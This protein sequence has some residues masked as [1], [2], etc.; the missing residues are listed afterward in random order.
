MDFGL[1]F[2]YVF[3]DKDWFR[4][5][6]ILSLVALIPIVGQFVLYGWMMKIARK[7]M[8]HNLESLPE[9]EF[10]EDLSR[11]FMGWVISLVYLLPIWIIYGLFFI[12]SMAG[13]Y[14]GFD[15]TTNSVSPIVS[16]CGSLFVIAYGLLIG[17]VLPAAFTRY[18]ERNS[19]GDAFNF[20][21]VFKMVTKNPGTYLIVLL[22]TLVVGLIV[23]FGL[24]AC[25]IG[26][27]WTATYAMA[28]QGHLYGQ[29]YNE[30]NKSN[31]IV[32]IPPAA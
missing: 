31:M 29:A 25:F 32:D 3:K 13:S 26:V 9:M 22:G 7:V 20:G 12:S 10:G 24:I 14:S 15:Q 21:E 16:I 17:L 11:G 23:P 8:D 27:I 28:V 5:I 4:K 6:S 2:S 19:L 18:L 1:A 30:V